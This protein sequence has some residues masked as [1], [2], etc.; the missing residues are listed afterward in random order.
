M[1]D[2][3]DERFVNELLDA[4]LKHYR[5]EDPRAGLENRI[6]ANVRAA[7]HAA[8][9]RGT[10]V[11][12]IA[13]SAAIVMIAAAAAYVSRRQ[14]ATVQ[15]PTPFAATKPVPAP[16]RPQALTSQS[17][18]SKPV[19]LARQ[20]SPA[21]RALPGTVRQV[22]GK[23]RRPEQFPTPAPLSEEEKLLLAYASQ[24]PISDTDNL[25]NRDPKIEPVEIPE[26]KIP[27]IE[28]E[29]LPKLGE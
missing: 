27:R 2:K 5:S 12:A 13:A 21:Q 17:E 23:T 28:I 14:P 7:G 1:D 25:L 22:A 3:R 11:W 20:T 8:R 16:K 19:T 10:W 15:V 26:L 29:E 9:P 18:A 4:S 24:V 6:L